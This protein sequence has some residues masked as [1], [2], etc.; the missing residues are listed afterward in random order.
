MRGSFAVSTVP[1]SEPKLVPDTP[2]RVGS[3]SGRAAIQ[4]TSA[5]P[6]AIQFAMREVQPDHRRFVLARPVDRQHRHA[7]V[8]E[9]IA[10]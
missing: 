7:A 5:G 3:S 4:S 1:N 2:M 9:F 8:E 10:V 6:V